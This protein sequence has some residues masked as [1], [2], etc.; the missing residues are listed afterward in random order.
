MKI[1]RLIGIT[2]YLLNRNVVS[3]RELAERFEV[4]VRTI[5]RDAE[6]LSIA[7]IPISSSTGA[8]G[9][10]EILDTFK[11]NKQITTMEDYLFIIT[12][13]KGMCSAYDNKKIN[14]TLEKL[15]TAGN[16][17]DEE[18]RVFIDFGVVREGENIPKFVREIEEAIRN[19]SIVEFDY[20][21]STGQKSHR[22]VE[23]LALNYRWYAWY[24]LAYC[25][26]KNDY[27][28]FKLNRLTDLIVTNHPINYEHGNVPELLEKQWS[29]DTRRYIPMKL[30]CK[31]EA[32]V[33]IMEYMKGKIVEVRENGDFVMVTHGIENERIWF[34]LLL[35]FGDSV[36]VLE[37][38]EIIDMLKEKTLQIQNL[39]R[40]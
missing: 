32:R 22:T 18:Q 13:L 17:K 24:L 33:P 35:G 31:A 27:R 12:A 25:T 15:L 20:T 7:G 39:Y 5:V 38:Q 11:L 16:Y 10:Y 1:D 30:L 6:V 40:D 21:D 37:P 14:T 3:A 28:L 19:K 9:G 4:S 2:M 26:C 29:N 8:S 36:E 34:S 23:P